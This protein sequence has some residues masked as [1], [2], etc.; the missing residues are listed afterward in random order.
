MATCGAIYSA[1]LFANLSC[2]LLR[3]LREKT[4][5]R[6]RMQIFI[7]WMTINLDVRDRDGLK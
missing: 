2:E 7:F 4:E 6:H 1:P 5:Q 3:F